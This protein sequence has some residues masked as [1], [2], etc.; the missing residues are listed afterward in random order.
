LSVAVFLQV[1]LAIVRI[2]ANVGF[3]QDFVTFV[4]AW[5]AIM[6]V[7]SVEQDGSSGADFMSHFCLCIHKTQSKPWFSVAV[8]TLVSTAIQPIILFAGG[9]Q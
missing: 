8:T 6:L 9:F 1:E 7:L 3:V 2:I 5:P 4:L